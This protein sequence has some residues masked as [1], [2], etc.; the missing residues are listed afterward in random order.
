MLHDTVVASRH[1]SQK[2]RRFQHGE[3]LVHKQKGQ[4]QRRSRRFGDHLLLVVIS[5]FSLKWQ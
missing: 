3:A 2:G 1:L 4:Q 5:H